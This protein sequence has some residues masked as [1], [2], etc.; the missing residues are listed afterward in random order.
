[1]KKT[2]AEIFVGIDVSKDSFDLAFFPEGKPQNLRN[3]KQDL[4]CLVQILQKVQP[5]LVVVEASGGYEKKIIQVLRETGIAVRRINPKRARDFAR[6][7]GYLAKTD[8]I[9]ALIL[10]KYASLIRE[11]VF[12]MEA[13]DE[14][15]ALK[16]RRDQVVKMLVDEKNRLRQEG[17]LIK[18]RIKKHIEILEEEKEELTKEIEE[19]LDRETKYEDLREKVAIL[20]SIPGVNLVTALNLL[21]E[22]PE[23]GKLNRRE[24]AAL[25]GLAPFNRDSGKFRGKR[26]IYGGRKRV[27]QTLFMA[28]MASIRWNGR[29]K[30]FFRRLR[31]EA[32][33][34]GKVAL[35]ACMRKLLLIMN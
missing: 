27:R 35:T 30:N 7:M 4:K 17:R 31:E 25:A 21:L 2:S 9:D 19:R 10:A 24:V 12:E 28:A 1:V 3:T 6:S 11:E 20:R 34:S 18:A 26:S 22:M 32:K 5:V 14:L 33:K 16:R 13:D 15:R 8:K 29:I 23:L